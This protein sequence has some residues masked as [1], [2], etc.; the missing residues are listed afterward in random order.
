M[1]IR[2]STLE[3]AHV[4]PLAKGMIS[5]F[6]EASPNRFVI[7]E[8]T[9]SEASCLVIKHVQDSVPISIYASDLRNARH[10]Q[11]LVHSTIS[12]TDFR[13]VM[14]IRVDARLVILLFFNF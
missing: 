8:K 5:N 6:P 12:P 10:T 9:S 1:L 11:A 7:L 3:F 4:L 13:E 2:K 14:G